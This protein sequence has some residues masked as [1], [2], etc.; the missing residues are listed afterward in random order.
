MWRHCLALFSSV[1]RGDEYGAGVRRA[2]WRQSTLGHSVYTTIGN[3]GGGATGNGSSP[4]R[5]GLS[6]GSANISRYPSS[7]FVQP[8]LKSPSSHRLSPDAAQVVGAGVAGLISAAHTS[9]I[10]A[11]LSENRAKESELGTSDVEEKSNGPRVQIIELKTAEMGTRKVSSRS[12]QKEYIEP[13][14]CADRDVC[15]TQS[16]CPLMN[17]EVVRIETES[18]SINTHIPAVPTTFTN[19]APASANK[20]QINSVHYLKMVHEFHNVGHH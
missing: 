20:V 18:F 16:E 13:A 5:P 10:A 15:R 12:D 17:R 11:P 3:A 19:S 6:S 14:A 7:I 9:T 1:R 4:T 2:A 8:A